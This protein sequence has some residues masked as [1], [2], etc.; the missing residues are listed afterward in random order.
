LD[1]FTF[2]CIL[3]VVVPYSKKTLESTHMTPFELSATLHRELSPVAPKLSAALN[4]ALNVIGEAALIITPGK[5]DDTTFQETERIQYGADGDGSGILMKIL[6]TLEVLE[7]HSTWRVEIERKPGP[8]P[9]LM[10]LR[11]TLYRIA[12][13]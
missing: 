11:Y 6:E 12:R 9:G 5:P 1:V 10:D 2:V 7:N 3:F 13:C 4:R 8:E